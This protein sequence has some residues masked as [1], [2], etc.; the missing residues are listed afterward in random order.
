M[1]TS[2]IKIYHIFQ[3]TEKYAKRRDYLLPPLN[4]FKFEFLNF[5]G[6]VTNQKYCCFQVRN[7]L[8]RMITEICCAVKTLLIIRRTIGNAFKPMLLGGRI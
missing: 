1:V 4:A 8:S 6:R 7:I 5:S 2:Y 3:P